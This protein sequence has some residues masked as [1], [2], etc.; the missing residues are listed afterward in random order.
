MPV[1]SINDVIQA[2]LAYQR[3]RIEAAAHNIATANQPLAAGESAALKTAG[4][5]PTFA[6][7]LDGA[8]ATVAAGAGGDT[9]APVNANANSNADV[10]LA[11]EPG[12]PAADENGMVRYPRVDLATEMTTMMSASRAYEATVRSY[13]IMKTLNAKALEIGK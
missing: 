7:Q 1:E 9:D 13:N 3:A 12:N 4:A 11:L 8:A 2:S 5:A 6:R 10:R